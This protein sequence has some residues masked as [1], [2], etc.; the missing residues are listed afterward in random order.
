MS[1]HTDLFLPLCSKYLNFCSDLFLKESYIGW[2]L[3][4]AYISYILCRVLFLRQLYLWSAFV[5][6][7]QDCSLVKCGVVMGLQLR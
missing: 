2:M 7:G 5:M 6:H 3:D 4:L 1:M